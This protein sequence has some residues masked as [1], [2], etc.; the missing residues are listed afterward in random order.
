MKK[1]IRLFSAILASLMV[2][3]SLAGCS[4]NGNPAVDSNS[5]TPSQ[6][7]EATPS[8]PAAPEEKTEVRVAALKG[9]TG[10]GMSKLMKDS[11]ENTTANS[12][13]FELAGAPDEIVGKLTSGSIDIAAIP[14]NLAAT[15]YNKT[16]G[17]IQIAAVNTLGTLYILEKGDTIKSIADLKGKTITATG[18]GATPEYALNYI[19]KQ[20]GLTPGKD[21]TVN[22]LT[23]HSELAALAVSG[24]ETLVLLP[25]PFVTTVLSKNADLRIAL[26]I[27][28]EWKAATGKA[29]NSDS[30]L[31]MGCIAV[32]KEFAENNK[33]ALDAFLT[34]YKASTEFV[35]ANAGE[36]S[37][38]VESEGIMAGAATIEK[39][40]PNCNIVYIDGS[41]MKNM[42]QS[43]LDILMKANPKSIGGKMPD[44]D[45]YYTK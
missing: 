31:A 42:T 11:K 45:F 22:Y 9:P 10:I 13:V 24:K 8:S 32:R 37:K 5:P 21:V 33:A 44:E 17:K 36:A 27:T 25:E 29:G 6:T 14:T 18:Q 28:D 16:S 35:S 30:E 1:S 7:V 2:L 4:G 20:N 43:F 15:L 34:E 23:E 3:L 39:A 26:D 38:I 40:I 19:L 12:Y 41:D